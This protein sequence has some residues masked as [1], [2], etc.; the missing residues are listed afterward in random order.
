[1]ICSDTCNGMAY[2]ESR[3][4]VHRDLA[5]RNVLIHED[6][7][8][9]VYTSTAVSTLLLLLFSGTYVKEAS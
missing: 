1:M 7:T 3:S 2:L 6:G 8:A 4:V 5:A 9:K